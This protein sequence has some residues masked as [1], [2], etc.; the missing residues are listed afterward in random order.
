MIYLKITHGW[1]AQH[2]DSETGDCVQQEFIP[3]DDEAVVRLAVPAGWEGGEARVQ[4]EAHGEAVV[5][6][7]ARAGE[8]ARRAR[9][10]ADVTVGGVPF[11]QQAEALVDVS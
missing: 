11:G 10:A 7:R 9:V 3:H 4:V 6:V 1:V 5:R 2:Y 8:P